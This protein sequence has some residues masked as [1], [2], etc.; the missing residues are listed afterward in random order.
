VTTIQSGISEVTASINGS[1]QTVELTFIA[2][3][4]PVITGVED[5]AGIHTGTLTSGKV[6]D[7]PLPTLSGTADSNATVRLFDNGTLVGSTTASEEGAWS[8]TPDNALTGEGDHSLSVTGALTAEGEQSS[9]SGAFILNLDTVAQLPV[10]ES[11]TD[12]N[13]EV[14]HTGTTN[15]DSVS[16]SGTTE[17]DATVDVYV[18]RMADRILAP[19]GTVVANSSGNW[20]I[21]ITDMRVFQTTGEYQFQAKTTDIAGN[22]SKTS[23]MD[24]YIVN[25]LSW[26]A[27]QGTPEYTI[28]GS[29]ESVSQSQVE[30]LL[31]GTGNAL[32]NVVASGGYNPTLDLPAS[33]AA[34]TG[35]RV[36]ISVGSNVGLGLKQ[37]GGGIKT[38]SANTNSTWYSTG[39]TW[40]QIY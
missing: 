29:G 33:S 13:G 27:P 40:K 32:F 1:S 25:Y 15:G 36:Y 24:P 2:A 21:A 14:E 8:V 12:S 35:N 37:N 4:I 7:D 31:S 16:L 20:Q 23:D 30:S 19:V 6:T 17:P 34:N 5:D 22:S 9:A 10:I 3:T 39:T 18:L 26:P 11:V 28:T 38:L